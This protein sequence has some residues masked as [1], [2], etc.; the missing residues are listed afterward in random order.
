MSLPASVGLASADLVYA[1]GGAMLITVGAVN[2]G[3]GKNE[4]KDF[5]IVFMSGAIF[6]LVGTILDA[7]AGS[8]LAAAATAVFDLLLW[9][10]GIAATIGGTNLY[11]MNHGL[12]YAGIFFIYVTALA[13]L[14]KQLL[15]ALA[16]AFLA[17]QVLTAAAAGYRNSPRLRW[18]SGLL[19]LIDGALFLILASIVALALPPP[20]GIIPP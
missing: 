3:L 6:L 15:L 2:M 10:I 20:L 19:A 14:T 16:L 11:A 18:I 9:M 8:P 13:A 4:L 1:V 7:L 12:L 5:G 17:I